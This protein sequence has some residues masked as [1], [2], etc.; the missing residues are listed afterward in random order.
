MRGLFLLLLLTNLAFFAW[1]FVA[2]NAEQGGDGNIMTVP[3]LNEG[4]TLLSELDQEQRPSLHEGTGE[5]AFANSRK[6]VSQLPTSSQVME[7]EAGSTEDVSSETEPTAGAEEAVCLSVEGIEAESALQQLLELLKRNDI[8][9]LTQGEKQG[10]KTNY[11]VM[12]PPYANRKKADEAAGILAAKKIKDFFIVRSGEYQNAV[13]LGVFSTRDRAK[14]RYEQ[15]VALKVRLRRP[16]IEAIAI[17]AKRYFVT[18][19]VDDERSAGLIGRLEVLHYPPA[20][21]VNCR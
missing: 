4:L 11:W 13:S 9:V 6:E 2:H 18:F 15:I 14:S 19:S 17:P 21:K 5:A 10:T 1:Q 20:R 12:L 16:K 3:P 7:G 8:T